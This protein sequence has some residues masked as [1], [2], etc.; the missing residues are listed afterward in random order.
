V[1]PDQIT[2][3]LRDIK[4][5]VAIPEPASPAVY[6]IAGLV[7]LALVL[8]ALAFR[9]WRRRSQ[10]R[11]ED[12]VARARREL[13]DADALLDHPDSELFAIE[14]S[15]VLRGYLARHLRLHAVR[16]TTEEFLA[17]LAGDEHGTIA[18]HRSSL[19]DFLRR[20]DLVKFARGG[21]DREQ[22]E[23]LLQSARAFIEA[24]ANPTPPADQPRPAPVPA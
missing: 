10:R 1:N 2:A 24:T 22:R 5:Q 19:R 17:A 9:W 13:A 4:P 3:Q 8:A 16:Q 15:D 18:A 23:Q 21:L 14:V 11:P 20:C 6:W 12:P 7:V